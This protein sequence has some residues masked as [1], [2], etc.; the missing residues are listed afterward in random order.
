MLL[1]L[2]ARVDITDESGS[3]PL[4]VACGLKFDALEPCAHIAKAKRTNGLIVAALLAHGAAPDR[5][6]GNGYN[7][8]DRAQ[9]SNNSHLYPL[10][11]QPKEMRKEHDYGTASDKAGPA[12]PKKKKKEKMA[13]YTA[14]SSSVPIIEKAPAQEKT[15][16]EKAAAGDTD[17]IAAWLKQGGDTAQCDQE[18]HNLLY[19]ATCHNQLPIM[20]VLFAHGLSANTLDEHKKNCWDYALEQANEGDSR[21]LLYYVQ[22]VSLKPLCKMNTK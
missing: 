3:T 5:R 7:A 10:L 8:R 14:Q 20:H 4:H 1:D 2:H 19:A 22:S 12:A 6:D 21:C 18:G 13:A 9:Q 17:A 11:P 16:F 15:I